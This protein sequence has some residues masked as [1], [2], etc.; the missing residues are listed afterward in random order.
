M[1][2]SHSHLPFGLSSV[3][4][5]IVVSVEEGRGSWCGRSPGPS[6]V[7]C[8]GPKWIWTGGV[9]PF[10]SSSLARSWK[11]QPRLQNIHRMLW[12]LQVDIGWEFLPLFMRSNPTF[13]MP[14]GNLALGMWDTSWFAFL[15]WRARYFL[16]WLW[17]GVRESRVV[18]SSCGLLGSARSF[19]RGFQVL[20]QSQQLSCH[21][22]WHLGLFRRM[23]LDSGVTIDVWITQ[24]KRQRRIHYSSLKLLITFQ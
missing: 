14:W 19:F 13:S 16:C 20:C 12:S 10:P 8:N 2:V 11:G 22:Q 18:S 3:M 4:H 7:F 17:S 5:D 9:S 24:N 15:L 23:E 21:S 1:T 6:D